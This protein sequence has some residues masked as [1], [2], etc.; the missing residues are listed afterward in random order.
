MRKV[1]LA[2]LFSAAAFA[3]TVLPALADS[4]PITP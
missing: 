3:M 2:F 1:T 4:S